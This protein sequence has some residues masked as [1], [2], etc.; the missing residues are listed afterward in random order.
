[1]S[2]SRSTKYSGKKESG[3]GVRFRDCKVEQ[4]GNDIMAYNAVWLY[5]QVIEKPVINQRTEDEG[6]QIKVKILRRP[7]T[8]KGG[9]ASGKLYVSTPIVSVTD[10]SLLL[11]VAKIRMGDMLSIRGVLSSCDVEKHSV[12]DCGNAKSALGITTYITALN[13]R[14]CEKGIDQYRGFELLKEHVVE[15]NTVVLLG[16]VCRPPESYEKDRKITSA[17][18]QIAVKS[19]GKHLDYIWVKNFGKQAAEAM[20]FKK[21]DDVFIE[22]SISTRT[23]S[24]TEKCDKCGI[25]YKWDETVAELIPYT[26]ARLPTPRATKAAIQED[27]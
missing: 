17:Q 20:S 8:N 23:I 4:K 16:S 21:G 25:E 13:I 10:K 19:N 3:T 2:K 27:N 18:Y 24:R 11:K 15:S 5:G 14:R 7:Y 12:C 9:I 22:G 26:S 1:M 6:A